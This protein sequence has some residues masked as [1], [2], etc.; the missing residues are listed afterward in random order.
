MMKLIRHH[1]IEYLEKKTPSIYKVSLTDSVVERILGQKRFSDEI[2]L[3]KNIPGMAM[4]LAW[5][6]FGGKILG[7]EVSSSKGSGGF[8]ITGNLGKVLQESI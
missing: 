1:I 5:T 3:N 8:K 7:V 6:Q 2:F 4:G